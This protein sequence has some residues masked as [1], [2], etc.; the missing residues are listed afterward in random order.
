MVITIAPPMVSGQG[1]GGDSPTNT[2]HVLQH[3]FYIPEDPINW[4]TTIGTVSAPVRVSLDPAGP[5]WVKHLQTE[6]DTPIGERTGPIV[7]IEENLMVGGSISWTGWHSDLATSGFIWYTGPGGTLPPFRLRVNDVP[8]PVTFA[9]NG[10]SLDVSFPPIAPGSTVNIVQKF[11][12]PHPIPFIGTIEM[13]QY[14]TPEPH[15]ALG[16][17]F[18]LLV[19]HRRRCHAATNSF[20]RRDRNLPVLE[21]T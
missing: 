1:V 8:V 3:V 5:P 11:G 18:L 15:S 21:R 2:S 13:H 12:W 10:S 4:A 7:G 19:L 20:R 6:N 14:P 17:M 9:I 16:A